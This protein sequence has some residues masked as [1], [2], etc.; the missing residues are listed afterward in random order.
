MAKNPDLVDKVNGIVKF[1]EDPCDAPWLVYLELAKEPLGRVVIALLS[2]GLDDVIRGYFRP[3]GLRSG[4]HGR[5]RR[6]PPP[7]FGA[8]G[9]ALRRIP[10][11]GDDVGDMLGKRLPG[12]ERVRGRQVNQGV[13]FL[14]KVDGVLQRVLWWWLVIDLTA[15]FFY[16]WTSLIQKSE[17]CQKTEP[18]SMLAEG[19]GGGAAAIAKWEPLFAPTIVREAPNVFWNNT[20]GTV[21][22]GL[23]TVVI[24]YD[25]LSLAADPAT[26]RVRV[27]GFGVGAE[28]FGE[29][30]PAPFDPGEE[31]QLVMAATVP[32][33]RT[34]VIE[35]RI[36][37]GFSVG[38][39]LT[40]WIT[41]GEEA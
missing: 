29:S 26:M 32:G 12:G 16:E 31:T 28:V 10:G 37:N 3:K 36:S 7:R 27:R 13:K 22:D 11:L 34:I 2:F 8:F 24:G 15:T 38:Q 40:V 5:R 1:L 17:F 33:P 14:W 39:D 41:G 30:D 25:C 35:Q 18:E 6:R 21:G 4:R 9:R 19:T 23:W 20:S